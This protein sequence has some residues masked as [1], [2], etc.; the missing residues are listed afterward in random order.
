[1]WP[2]TRGKVT[3][4]I[5]LLE[6]GKRLV[7]KKSY[8]WYRLRKDILSYVAEVGLKCRINCRK[9]NRFFLCPHR[10]LLSQICDISVTMPLSIIC[11]AIMNHAT[12]L[13]FSAGRFLVVD[14]L[15]A[16]HHSR[17]SR[18][19]L[20]FI[21]RKLVDYHRF[22]LFYFSVPVLLTCVC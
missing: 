14:I 6:A 12:N 21:C 15:M 5:P 17:S 1:M 22:W 19:T 2:M 7:E 4:G 20:I 3:K 8:L 10:E 18:S 13:K 11:I 9:E 16:K